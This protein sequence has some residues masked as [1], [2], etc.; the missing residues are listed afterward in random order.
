MGWR[1]LESDLWSALLNLGTKAELLSWLFE[2]EDL[3]D[4]PGL[5]ALRSAY[6]REEGHLLTYGDFFA[7]LNIANAYR[8]AVS[9]PFRSEFLSAISAGLK[10]LARRGATHLHK[11]LRGGTR[12]Y[13]N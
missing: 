12:P 8:Y 10:L 11:Y 9:N 3:Y 5:S 7:A 2:Y 6:A 4:S 13:C 1:S